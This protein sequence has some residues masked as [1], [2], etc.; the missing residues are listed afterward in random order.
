VAAIEQSTGQITCPECGG[1]GE[2]FL[3]GR[4]SSLDELEGYFNE[5]CEVTDRILECAKRLA[6]RTKGELEFAKSESNNYHTYSP[7][8]SS[9]RTD[10]WDY[11]FILTPGAVFRMKKSLTTKRD[12][13]VKETAEYVELSSL[14]DLLVEFDFGIETRFDYQTVIDFNCRYDYNTYRDSFA[15]SA[16]E[17]KAQH[18]KGERETYSRKYKKGYGLL[19]VLEKAS[20]PSSSRKRASTRK[21][22]ADLIIYLH[23]SYMARIV[24]GYFDGASAATVVEEFRRQVSDESGF[25]DVAALKKAYVDAGGD[26]DEPEFHLQAGFLDTD[27]KGV[28]QALGMLAEFGLTSTGLESTINQIMIDGTFAITTDGKTKR[29]RFTRQT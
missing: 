28:G 24:A 8:T 19:S 12:S 27:E 29:A 2:V 3:L 9:A 21:E 15:N 26:W 7:V 13:T 6:G 18:W 23:R 22:L 1:E 17:R 10:T 5:P 11:S 25:G 16:G 20:R 14:D 4:P